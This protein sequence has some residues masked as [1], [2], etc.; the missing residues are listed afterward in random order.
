MQCHLHCIDDT[1]G[2]QQHVCP[3]LMVA[4]EMK[5][6]RTGVLHEPAIVLLQQQLQML[7]CM[8]GPTWSAI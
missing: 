8:L 3:M 7:C 1:A 2:V 6:H 4:P 5:R